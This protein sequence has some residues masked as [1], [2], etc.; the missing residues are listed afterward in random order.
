M[1]YTTSGPVS[2][3]ELICFI[4]AIRTR[5]LES[6]SEQRVLA[7][8]SRAFCYSI[9]NSHFNAV[10]V[11]ATKFPGLWDLDTEWT[12]FQLPRFE[13]SRAMEEQGDRIKPLK[14]GTTAELVLHTGS[15]EQCQFVLRRLLAVRSEGKPNSSDRGRLFLRH[16]RRVAGELT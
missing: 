4:G 12:Q 6:I 3:S 9:L 7:R 16:R 11:L 14:S 1:P 2:R 5:I 10:E 15:Y 8:M 13:S